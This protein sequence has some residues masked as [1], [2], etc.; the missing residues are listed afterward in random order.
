[1]DASLLSL[2]LIALGGVT[3]GEENRRTLVGF[4]Q[5]AFA[6]LRVGRPVLSRRIASA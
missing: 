4:G 6:S 3:E 1:M 5:G 2:S